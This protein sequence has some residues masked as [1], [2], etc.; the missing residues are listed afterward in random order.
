MFACPRLSVRLGFAP[1]VIALAVA[2]LSAL[3][4]T[5][6]PAPG[7]DPAGPAGTRIIDA[8]ALQARVAADGAVRVIVGLDLPT[9]PEGGLDDRAMADQRAAIARAQSV[10]T[11]DFPR[12]EV[13]RTYQTIPFVALTVPA[14]DLGALLARR[15]VRSVVVDGLRA[16][17]LSE[18]TRIIRARQLR[19]ATGRDGSGVAV[20]VLDT[21]IRYLHRAFGAN[22]ERVVASACFSSNVA[23]QRISSLC[24][25]R[26][27]R[28]IAPRAA[29]E[30]AAS[31]RGCGHGTH[32]SAI[33]GS[34]QAGTP[35]VAPAVD[36]IAVQVFSRVDRADLCGGSAPCVLAFDSDLVA[37]LE[38]VANLARNRRV[39]AVN[40]SLGGGQFAA[41]C[42]RL[43]PAFT[44]AAQTLLSRGVVPIAAT[45]NNGFNGSVT[46]PACVPAVVGVGATDNQDRIAAFSNQARFGTELMA[47]GVRINAAQLPAIRSRARMSGTSMAAPH[48]A[49]AVALL[50]Q[51]RPRATPAQILGALRCS[52]VM[53]GPRAGHRYHRINVQRART[54]LRRGNT[55]C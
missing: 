38:F 25:E 53:V 36:L 6:Q 7:A 33:V 20:A 11:G 44:A 10:L 50:R 2:C 28:H 32:V 14:G 12:A 9:R 21:G 27:T 4:A 42:P 49:G 1:L 8:P 37:G 51:D 34:Q 41:G 16:P 43:V 46:F 23:G 55:S 40:M 19:V 24:R 26:R 54:Y 39:A 5:A 18:S 17:S 30:C 35:G 31:I 3:A 15:D 45:G 13:H 48:V 29:P 22:G 52:A 47:P